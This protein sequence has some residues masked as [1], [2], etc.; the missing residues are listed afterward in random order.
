MLDAQN[1]RRVSPGVERNLVERPCAEGGPNNK[2]KRRASVNVHPPPD[3]EQH[4]D[5]DEPGL[6]ATCPSLRTSSQP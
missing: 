4:I 2:R 6:I 3:E 5:I 1:K